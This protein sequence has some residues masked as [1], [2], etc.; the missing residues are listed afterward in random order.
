M[1]KSTHSLSFTMT[2]TVF[3]VFAFNACDNRPGIH[4]FG[5][6]LCVRPD[7]QQIL[8]D[9]RPVC[10]LDNSCGDTRQNPDGRVGDDSGDRRNGT[11]N[12]RGD[13]SGDTVIQ[14]VADCML[15]EKVPGTDTDGDCI[16]DSVE[17]P[18]GN[19]ANAWVDANNNGC[20]DAV[21]VTG[22]VPGET[23]PNNPD[24][25][26]DGILDGCEDKNYDGTW[27]P[28]ETV[29]FATG[30]VNDT[31]C[32]GIRD[33]LEDTNLNGFYERFEG[34]TDATRKDTDGDGIDDGVEDAN[35]DGKVLAFVDVNGDGCFQTGDTPGESDPRKADTDGD[36]L[37]DDLEDKNKDGFWA[38]DETSAWLSDTDCDKL[39]D[40]AEDRNLD[41]RRAERS[42]TDPL[43]ADT[44]GDGLLD[45]VETADGRYDDPSTETNPLAADTDGDFIPDGVEDKNLNGV[46]DLYI[47]NNGN[48]CFDEGDTGGETNPRRS[49]SDNDGIM[50]S[51]E[52]RNQN[53][54]CETGMVPDPTKPGTEIFG[55]LESCAFVA[56]T[57]CDGLVDGDE[58]QNRNGTFEFGE[59]D[60]RR[61]DTDLDGLM[62]GCP[63]GI[64]LSQCEDQN[65]NGIVDIG[66]TDPHLVDTD[67]DSLT[68][69]CEVNFSTT[70]C[71]DP[72]T[73][74]GTDPISIDTD[75]DGITDGEEDGNFNCTYEPT[76]ENCDEFGNCR[77]E[78][79]PRFYDEPPGE[80][81]K[82]YAQ[83][84]VCASQNLKK[85][86]FAESLRYDYRLAF[87]VEEDNS[88]VCVS[89][90]ECAPG[91]RCLGGRCSVT[92]FV[93][94]IG[95]DP[96][97][98][99]F[100]PDDSKDKLYGHTF[101]S[102]QG[103]IEVG[104][105]VQNREIYGFVAE[106]DY[107]G[108]LDARLDLLRDQFLGLGMFADVQGTGSLLARPA[109]DNMR[110]IEPPLSG[111]FRILFSQR[112]FRVTLPAGT[113]RSSVFIRNALLEN[114]FLADVDKPFAPTGTPQIQM[115]P[116]T[117]LVF[118]NVICTQPGAANCYDT[119]TVYVTAVQRQDQRTEGGLRGVMHTIVAITP[120]D[121]AS[122]QGTVRE[123]DERLARLEDLTG[124]SAF[125]RYSATTGRICENR[126][127]QKAV[128]DVL[129]VVD[130]SGSMQKLIGALQQASSAA[131][132]VFTTNSEIV[133]FR[134][135][136]TTTNPSRTARV[137]CAD[138]VTCLDK[139]SCTCIR[140]CP[141]NCNADCSDNGGS[142]ACTGQCYTESLD[143]VIENDV[144][145]SGGVGDG[146]KHLPG[147]G[148]TFYY[149]DNAFLDCD[150][151]SP[152]QQDCGDATYAGEFSAFYNGGR[153][154]LQGNAGFIGAPPDNTTCSTAMM[155]LSAKVTTDPSTCTNNP[156]ACCERLLEAC[157]DGP[158][159][160]AS[161]MCN[162]IREMGGLPGSVN[163]QGS[164][165]T[166]S[167]PEQGSRGARRLI[168]SM[169]PALPRDYSGPLD[170]SK[171][172]RLDCD[173]GP[174]CQPCNPGDDGCDEVVPLVTIILSDE[175]DY[176]F[177]D[178]CRTRSDA[179]Q[180]Q[181]P[182]SCYWVDGDPSTTEA[183]TAAYCSGEGF[184]TDGPQGYY[185]DNS[186]RGTSLSF[187]LQL[188]SAAAPQCLAAP[189]DL[190][191]TC[192][193][194][195][196]MQPGLNE[197]TCNAFMEN[198][199]QICRWNVVQCE[200][201]CRRHSDVGF[202]VASDIDNLISNCNQDPL[203][204]WDP[205]KVDDY[206]VPRYLEACVADHPV[207]DCAPCKRL[208]RT[209]D[210]VN[211][212]ASDPNM[213]FGACENDG[214]PC[215]IS[216]DCGG[217]A[218]SYALPGF[219]DIGPL[220]AIIREAGKQ[221]S[222]NP[223]IP[224][225]STDECNG[226]NLTWGRG[227]GQG[228]RDLAAATLGRTQNVCADSYDDFIAL[229]ISD[230]AALSAP[231]PLTKAPIA[232]TIK[233]GIARP[234]NGCLP[235]EPDTCAYD[236]FNVPRSRTQGFFYSS[237]GN[238]IA[239]KNDPV[240]GE[241]GGPT[242]CTK[243]QEEDYALARPE[244]PRD[245][246][247]IYI[248]YRF[249]DP[250][251]CSGLCPEGVECIAFLCTGEEE[252]DACPSGSDDECPSDFR[253]VDNACQCNPGDIV[254]GCGAVGPCQR[255]ETYDTLLDVCTPLDTC[256]CNDTGAITC[257]PGDAASCPIGL[258]CNEGCVCA[259][260]P[261]CGLDL[262]N[263]AGETCADALTCCEDWADARV[264]CEA[265]NETACNEAPPQVVC[266]ALG[267][268][269]AAACDQ[270]DPCVWDSTDG[271]CAFAYSTCCGPSETAR[272]AT[273]ED[274]I[275]TLRCDPSCDCGGCTINEVCDPI[276][277]VCVFDPN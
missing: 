66:E 70:S 178:D 57:D 268:N 131:R 22:E 258:S 262:T 21:G 119:F 277:C 165:R 3:S 213:D 163:Q 260:T 135:A 150:S 43:N 244:V 203:C 73:C 6:G 30:G 107:S 181:L 23:D 207:N 183:C 253:C 142:C 36:L 76:V 61:A 184:A 13:G 5:D 206:T 176:F 201:N 39:S 108:P 256:D 171:H 141:T 169:L 273:G 40:G 269:G 249:W 87:E 25:D 60:A 233:V 231:Y 83:W 101:Q 210:A 32:D 72:T 188:D 204:K 130:D 195:P 134:L 148:G 145:G 157:Q 216:A 185:P 77:L 164:A 251:P 144:Y 121:R 227:D 241:C 42:E 74:G 245:N 8:E 118:G 151:T 175:E 103:I 78:T 116:Q 127:Q 29:A 173:T 219:G 187:S 133:D 105:E 218:C 186:A 223:A 208:L 237:T 246:D 271:L 140:L 35:K 247:T 123:Y 153:V 24:T 84:R 26:G 270:A 16:P 33:E 1:T 55:Y 80:G 97:G 182:K 261:G 64:N 46:V 82:D 7:G 31:D 168:Q 267:F 38:N 15:C 113:I 59:L 228:Y 230:I 266:D 56:D 47:D 129:W 117:D 75:G 45:G 191:T 215:K 62:D 137:Q 102:P 224:A 239:F 86:T 154:K 132:S 263:L 180:S 53:G 170:A 265:L 193:T 221:G 90:G 50:D 88:S 222:G 200:S 152:R 136:L 49:D 197:T 112:T 4:C 235:T 250:V 160:L 138:T 12:D 211:G 10:E 149:E 79:D 128:A 44:D 236:Y 71:K 257:T 259:K 96:D 232:S 202:S 94:P 69:G 92:Y 98:D 167:A 95:Y 274:E 214:R 89:N 177:K 67:G 139:D 147:G 240:S 58:D 252:M 41:G 109:H 126:P 125:A 143:D 34:E 179:D 20:F 255:C 19:G 192:L 28:G 190:S 37:R 242:T 65:N 100:T 106:A 229:V 220:Y 196:C 48:G 238:T 248:S 272:C 63:P 18:G 114:V 91:Q 209:E 120:D 155:D 68:D 225:S 115:P 172:L 85:L 166:S 194:D 17:D 205:S 51:V 99:G 275:P 264:A 27:D 174:G 2:A 199:T 93:H 217:A 162:L 52:D 110:S 234:K 158:L 54:I 276:L 104:G 124:G 243:Q 111:D 156:D 159:V 122:A 14:P 226:G 198:G 189:G 161:Q 212:L 254:H 81:S 9:G 11:D 146:I